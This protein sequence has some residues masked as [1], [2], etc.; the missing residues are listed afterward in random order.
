[1]DPKA[2][3]NILVE[4]M[5]DETLVYDLD[6]HRAHTLNATAAFLLGAADGTRSEAELAELASEEFGS[7][8]TE[9]V[10]RLGL[11]RLERASLLE[12][13]GNIEIPEGVTRR[14]AIRRLAL[15]GILVPTV[16]TVITPLPGQAATNIPLT[17]CSLANAGKCCTNN[18]LCIQTRRGD[19]KCQGPPC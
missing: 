6:R 7:P 12:W 8:A 3:T 9:E 11:Q 15:V 17:A 18:K 2:K 19:Y 13:G 5:A 4:E 1:M 14:Q 10:V 16:M